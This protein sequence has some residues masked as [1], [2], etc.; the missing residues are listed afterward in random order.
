[1]KSLNG[2]QRIGV[3]L[4]LLWCT[5]TAGLAYQYAGFVD[6]DNLPLLYHFSELLSL[7]YL[8]STHKVVVVALAGILPI[9][10]GWLFVYG[11]LRTVNWAMAGF[12][13]GKSSKHSRNLFYIGILT[14]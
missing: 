11:L 6:P 5:F 3:V 7:A 8:G 12:N 14:F 2:W 13:P 4:S 9:A 1:M 10:C